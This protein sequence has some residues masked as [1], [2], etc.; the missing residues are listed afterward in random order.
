MS[1]ELIEA[2]IRRFLSS[3]DAEVLCIKGRWGVGK[4][5]GWRK[6][7]A[8][9]TAAR[10]VALDR[11]SYVSLFGLNSLEDLRYSIFESTTSGERL[12]TSPDAATFGQLVGNRGDFARKM[13]PA[14]EAVSAFF[15]RKSVTDV[16]F[17][18]AFLT[19]RQQL[20]CLDD[21]ERAGTGLSARDVLGL[22]SFLKEERK[23]KI[24]LLLNDKEIGEKDDFD[25]Q[26]EKV[27]DVTVVFDLKPDEAVKI[28]LTGTDRA[29]VVMKPFV[30]ALGIT[31]IRVIKKI[32]R[33]A[34]RLVAILQDLDE[35]IVEKAVATLVLASWSV[36]QPGEAPPLPFLKTYN[37]IAIAMRAGREEA[38]ADT[39]RFRSRIEGYPFRGPEGMDLAVMDG[40][41]AGYFQETNVYE[42]AEELQ[43]SWRAHSRDNAFSRTWEQ[44]YHGSLATDD[45]TFLDALHRSAIDEAGAI[46]PLNI[47]GAVRVLR[48]YGRAD[49]ANE[50]VANYIVAHDGDGA[51]FFEIQQ[52]HFSRDDL[53]DDALREAFAAKRIAFIDERDPLEVLRSI[54]ER[55]TW[56]DADVELLARQSTDDFERLFETLQ[57]DP[58]KPAIETLLMIGNNH[59]EGRAQMRA[60]AVEALRRIA[61]KSP[62]RARKVESFGVRLE[63]PTEEGAPESE[64]TPAR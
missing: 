13:R 21:L 59:G 24:I 50:V 43:R 39:Q 35:A 9:A 17:K 47:N 15:N 7:L 54:G 16:L 22:A 25:K 49:Q 8:D 19:V 34:H 31:N 51:N 62:L 52:H 6:F 60:A 4:T 30:I 58:L 46:T 1:L 32:E 33:L 42:A 64:A 10:K 26:L 37:R 40:A 36:Q 55:R 29:T 27:A 53:L 44:L 20:V 5:Y 57:G 48:E 56:S 23:C 61:A 45:E 12:G 38:D 28:A 18:S 2:E 11:Y 14:I 3:S 41:A 63:E